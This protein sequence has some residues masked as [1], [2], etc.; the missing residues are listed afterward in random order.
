MSAS[1]SKI[2]L[3]TLDYNLTT[4][5]FNLVRRAILLNWS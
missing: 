5:D 2:A 4:L 3:I 1:I